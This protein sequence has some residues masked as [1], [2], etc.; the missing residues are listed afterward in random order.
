MSCAGS[1]PLGGR[2]QR[3]VGGVGGPEDITSS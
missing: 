3:S 2:A 1:P